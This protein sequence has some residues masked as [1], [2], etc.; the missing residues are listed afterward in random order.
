MDDV[1][2]AYAHRAAEYIELLGS[3]DA[4][5]PSDRQLID[6]WGGS[7]TG[8]VLDAGCGPGHWSARLAATGLDVR[9][10]DATAPFIEHA[11][12]AH[13]EVTFDLGSLDH[14][15]EPDGALGGVLA[16]YSTIH[17]EPSRLAVPIA[18]F[19]RVLRP[20]GTL[21]LGFFD[22]PAIERFDHAVTPAYRWPVAAVQSILEAGRFE[23]VET[24]RRTAPGH[25]PHAA[26][27]ARRL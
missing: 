20:H 18:E 5:H 16:W 4:A 27:V 15:A 17:H 6:T 10:I 3:T 24:Q 14:I 8:R 19:A 9:G 25:R 1:S 26:V 21:L 7:V 12:A 11:R 23:V 22:G 13:P 2:E